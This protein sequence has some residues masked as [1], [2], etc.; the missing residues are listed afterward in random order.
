MSYPGFVS[1]W[2]VECNMC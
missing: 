1:E 2:K